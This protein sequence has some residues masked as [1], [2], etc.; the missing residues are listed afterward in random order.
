MLITNF[1]KLLSDWQRWHVPPYLM[2][3]YHFLFLDEE[4]HMDVH[5]RALFYYRL[6]KTGAKEV[7]LG[8]VII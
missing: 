1:I 2:L 8:D 4:V 7:L 6:L 3:F 5:D